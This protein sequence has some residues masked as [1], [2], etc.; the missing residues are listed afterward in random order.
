MDVGFDANDT[1]VVTAIGNDFAGSGIELESTKA[2]ADFTGNW[3]GTTNDATILASMSGADA[4]SVNFSSLLE[5]GTDTS[6]AAGFQGD[7]SRL[8]V[9][10]LG[11]GTNR[12]GEA[13]NEVT[14]GGTINVLAGAYTLSGELDIT[15]SL[16]LIGAGIGN[17]T[18]TS[19]STGYGIN[20]TADN[21][22]LSGFTFNAP[23]A[24]GGSTYGI[25]VTP[26][27]NVASDRLLNFD[28][29]HV[30]INGG[31]RTGLD[32]N[33]VLGA[34]IDHVSVSNVVNGNGIALTDS[35]NVTLTNDT[36]TNNAWG[37]LAL[38]QHNAT[39]NQ[40]VNNISVNGTNT[41]NEA[42]GIYAEDQSTTND[43]GTLTL[44]GYNFIAQNLAS[45]NDFYTFFQKTEQGA[46]DIAALEGPTTAYV[47]GYAGNSTNGNNTFYVGTST[48]HTA[49][50]IIA[51]VNAAATGADV[52]VLAGTYALLGEL[53]ITKSIT[54]EGAGVGTTTINSSSTGYGINVTADNT[55]LSGFTFNGSAAGTYGIKVTPDTNVAS[56]RLLN[57]DID[58]VAING[59]RKTGLDLNGV[60]GATIA[61]VS[62][63]NTAAGNGIALTDSANVTLTN[64][65][66]TNNAWGGLALYQT[67]KFYNQQ[68]NNISVDGTN[69]FNEA[70][71]VYAEDQSSLF[72]MGSL[73]LANYSFVVRSP[74]DPTDVYTFFQKTAQNAI[75]FATNATA[76]G[77]HVNLP[78][79]YVEGWTGSAVDNFFTVGHN[80]AGTVAL[81][82]NA[83]VNAASTGGT[84]DVESG[85]YAQDA[86]VNKQ[87][88][89]DFGNVTLNSLTLTSGAAGSGIEGD[90][91]A[92]SVA[93]N[94]AVTLL[95]N[96]TL[97]TSAANGAISVASVDGTTAGA[98]S[99]TLKSGTGHVTLGN[100]GATTRL[101]SLTDNNAT[102]LT[103]SS[104]DAN[105]I[106]VG[107][108]TL[109]DDVTLGHQRRQR[110]D[111]GRVGR[112]HDGWRARRSTLKAGSGN[113]TLGNTGAT[114]RLGALTDHSATTLTGSAYDANGIAF[115]AVTLAD[116]VTLDT[117]AANGAISVASVDGTSAGGQSLT[118]KAGTGN[119][120]LGNTGATTRL[121]SLTDGS[122]TTLTGSSY[123]ANSIGFGALTLADDVTL[124][125]SVAN[126]AIS[127]ASVDGT[128][129]GSES[130][131]L[132]SGTG[133]VTLGNAGATTRLASLTDNNATTLTGSAYDAN[134][135][136][137][138]ALT[139]ADDVTL[140]TSV[141][142]GAI[143]VAS[144]DGTTA[145]A[146]S[147]TLKAGSGN[148]TL[149]N[150]G[151]TTRLA[152]LTDGFSD[153]QQRDHADRAPATMPTASVFGALTARRR[154]HPGHQCR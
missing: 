146:Q 150:A 3:W 79:A 131:T 52:N 46:I 23:T 8:E 87:L 102:T 145:G 33:G 126:G 107:A 137:F 116:D 69:T 140:D 22:T 7:F 64:D 29:D 35:A 105:S 57:F 73:Q 54:L 5:S 44:A 34:T 135:I 55:T 59:S 111:L 94:G 60:V 113:V 13:V 127:V 104:Y 41:F 121:A 2:T 65:A 30:A 96:L 118:L 109:A 129:A 50:S 89:L 14:T 114:T 38:Y 80:T 136:S 77:G 99:L 31:Y 139:L 138:G 117:S 112:R 1:S 125:T 47:Q 108:L 19:N 148:V 115:G 153:R 100:A 144:V 42:N 133:H 120:T 18:I 149:G 51:A 63:S 20:V 67:N 12:I 39:Y 21:T 93:L 128:T 97:D 61:N 53:D 152:S 101:A 58:H 6:G 71:G 74:N 147:L 37:G 56:D 84:I 86:S 119:V 82:I 151:A 103:G 95:N 70:N 9:T 27:T 78:T 49:L 81:Q 68:V 110:C 15:K 11:G 154:R 17:T 4:G 141:A 36:T 76:N 142:N 106:V 26:D 130:L 66:T 92:G 16:S 88:I 32:L 132:T 48:N 72:D 90:I 10:S 83:A 143:S 25:K 40:Q 123:D 24:V 62:V 91:T 134:S 122:A 28:I 85:T 75:D 43:F 124:D 45:P 98:Q